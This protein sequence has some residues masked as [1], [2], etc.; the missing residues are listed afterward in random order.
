LELDFGWISYKTGGGLAGHNGLRSI[1]QALGTEAFH[2]FR[3]GI[4]R[5]SRGEVASYVLAKFSKTEEPV[6]PIFLAQA[7]NIL[8]RIVTDK[9]REPEQEY[10]KLHLI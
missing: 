8:M 3:I 5:P 4:G 6:L 10:K 2:R 7:A 9:V 1:A